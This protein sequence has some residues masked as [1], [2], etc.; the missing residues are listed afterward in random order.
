MNIEKRKKTLFI[1]A[2]VV[3]TLLTADKL[4]WPSL[5]GLWAQR[6]V[7]I[8]ELKK[9]IEQGTML[10]KREKSVRAKW[11]NMM[12]TTLPSDASAAE[13]KILK[14]VDS[15]AQ[16]SRVNLSSI[17]PQWKQNPKDRQNNKEYST[18]ECR[19]D[20]NG[21]MATLSRFLYNLEQDPLP[22]R[23]EDLQLTARDNLGQELT[24]SVRFTGLAL[25][26]QNKEQQP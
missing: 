20:A 26:E 17:K 11:S 24:L 15:W 23:I 8:V 21:D 4:L 16:Q 12:R 13:I 19:V 1:A 10:L 18:L 5:S 2:I 6:A 14:S 7:R 22:L 3:I 9:N 25:V